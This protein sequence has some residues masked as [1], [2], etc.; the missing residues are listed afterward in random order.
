MQLRGA[1]VDAAGRQERDVPF[2]DDCFESRRALLDLVLEP[3]RRS[4]RVG[5]GR[6]VRVRPRGLLALGRA[7]RV[8]GRVLAEEHER[9]LRLTALRQLGR[10]LGQ[11]VERLGQVDD[12]RAAGSLRRP[13]DDGVQRPVDLDDRGV[14]LD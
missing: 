13:G 3:V 8:A 4:L 5:V 1:A 10:V 11:R 6:H 9:P 12:G 14:R 7:R 2:A